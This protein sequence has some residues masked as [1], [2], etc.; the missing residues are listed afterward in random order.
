MTTFGLEGTDLSFLGLLMTI[1]AIFIAPVIF[2]LIRVGRDIDVLK[3]KIE[4]LENMLEIHISESKRDKEKLE[5]NITRVAVLENAVYGRKFRNG[6]IEESD[7][8]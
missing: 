6:A 1:F 2:F 8:K 7:D 5:R 3:E 4:H